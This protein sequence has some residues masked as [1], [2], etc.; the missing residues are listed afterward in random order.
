MDGFNGKRRSALHHTDGERLGMP[1][2]AAFSFSAALGTQRRVLHSR[3]IMLALSYAIEEI[4]ASV[5]DTTLI[6]AFQRL[7]FVRPQLKRYAALTPHLA[8]TYILGLPDIVLPELPHTTVIPLAETWPV[9]HEWV[10]LATGPA[11]RAGLFAQDPDATQPAQRSRH[12]Q[13]FWTADADIV[14]AA[15][16]AFWNAMGQPR[17]PQPRDGPALRDTTRRVQQ[18]IVTRLRSG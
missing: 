17:P 9:L 14:D 18:A 13:G 3:Q 6:V 1:A 12:F 11:C 2:L 4:V 15:V 5:P 10:V 8:H 7:S 16:A